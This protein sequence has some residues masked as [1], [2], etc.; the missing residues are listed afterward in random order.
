MVGY[1]KKKMFLK[2]TLHPLLPD[3]SDVACIVELIRN[4]TLS[5]EFN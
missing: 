1:N 2:L 3:L 4:L 5:C